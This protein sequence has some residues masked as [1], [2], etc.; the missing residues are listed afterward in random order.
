MPWVFRE[1]SYICCSYSCVDDRW[2]GTNGA[3]GQSFGLV[4]VKTKQCHRRNWKI[5]AR[6]IPTR[7]FNGAVL[8]ADRQGIVYRGGFGVANGAPNAAFTPDT[9]SCLASLS[10]PL[11]ALAVMMLAKDGFIKYDNHISE[12][13][14]EL[15]PALGAVTIR[16]LLT[17]TSGIPDYSDLSVE[18]PGMTN[19]DVLRALTRVDHTEFHPGEKYQYSNSG[20]VLLSILVERVA[21]TPLSEFLQKRIFGPLRMLRSFALT[22]ILLKNLGIL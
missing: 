20:Y 13:I 19:A 11:T 14:P 5:H 7:Q 17:H 15:P 12:Y 16:Q 18:H 2:H 21:G 9:P 10:K 4:V 8:L 22:S 1:R 6:A 3:E